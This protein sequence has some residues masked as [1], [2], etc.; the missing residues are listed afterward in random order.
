MA[1]PEK[2]AVLLLAHGSPDSVEDVPEFL[3]RVTGGRALPQQ[4]IEEV[5]H[6]YGL[7]GRPPLTELTLKQAELLARELGLPVYVGMRNWKPFIAD[8]VRDMIS[9]GVE[10]AVAIC[11]A[12]QDSRTSV[13]LYR[14]ALAGNQ[15]PF[16]V[17]FVESWHEH[18]LLIKAFAEKLRAGRDRAA[19]EMGTYKVPVI[20]TAH[21]VP[22]RTIAEGDPY[23]RQAKETASLVAR[24]AGLTPDDWAF[25]FQSQGM[26]GGAWL[27]P[28]VEDTILGLKEK[29][30]RGVFVQP[31]GFLCD[32]VEVLY[33]IDILFKQFAQKEE[34]Q[35]R[36]AE[37]LNDSPLLTA[38]LADIVRSRLATIAGRS[39]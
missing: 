13:G 36:R 30:Y 7:I 2:A 17:D 9:G 12:P 18:P 21:S 23:E 26:S 34:M 16:T 35:L 10:N 39:Q 38:A 24:E 15:A 20:F 28:R 29:G 19:R 11:M 5:K 27:G 22:E 31:I 4:V 3:L 33:D 8:A 37:S 32:H 6:R 25:A 14:S 1:H